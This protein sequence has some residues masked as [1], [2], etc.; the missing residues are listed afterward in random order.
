MGRPKEKQERKGKKGNEDKKGR[1]CK[2]IMEK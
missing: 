2:H 1:T